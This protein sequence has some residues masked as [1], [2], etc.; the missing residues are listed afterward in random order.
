MIRVVYRFHH[1]YRI[2]HLTTLILYFRRWFWKS[3]PFIFS[4]FFIFFVAFIFFEFE[5]LRLNFKYLS[6]LRSHICY[7]TLWKLAHP[8]TF[9]LSALMLRPSKQATLLLFTTMSQIIC[10]SRYPP[11]IS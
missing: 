6:L 10:I 1:R 3:V 8:R 5:S 4:I 9:I 11:Q 7:F 2:L